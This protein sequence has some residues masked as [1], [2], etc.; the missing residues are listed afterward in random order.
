MGSQTINQSKRNKPPANPGHRKQ[1]I[2]QI[3]LPLIFSVLIIIAMAVLAAISTGQDAQIGTNMTGIAIIWLI[4]PVIIIGVVVFTLLV[5]IIYGISKLLKVTPIYTLV[6]RN[7]VYK[8]SAWVRQISD[9]S[10]QPI[11]NTNSTWASI[12][13]FL[14]VI[15]LRRKPN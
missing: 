9:R 12:L 2:W 7:Y 8:G 6:A 14:A 4:T 1:M 15:G 13:T 11:I 3:W 5:L 10:V